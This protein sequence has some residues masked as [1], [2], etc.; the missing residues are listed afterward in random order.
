MQ[1][2]NEANEL[3]SDHWKEGVVVVQQMTGLHYNFI[4]GEIW[5]RRGGKGHQIH[6]GQE[7]DRLTDCKTMH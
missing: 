1:H 6:V 5:R 7:L 2:S 3:L 4:W